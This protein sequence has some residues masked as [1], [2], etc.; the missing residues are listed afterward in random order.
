[1]RY[2]LDMPI[3]LAV[4]EAEIQGDA[5]TAVNLMAA[6]LHTR[7]PD[8]VFWRP[9]RMHRLVQLS[10]LAS[11]LPRWATS[12][13]ILAQAH[14][15]V[16]PGDRDRA[17]QAMEIAIE[18]RGPDTLWGVDEIDAR[19]KVMDHDW[20]YRQVLLY[21]LG[22]LQHFIGGVASRKLLGGADRIHD[23]ARAPMGAF[24]LQSAH[25]STLVWE[26]LGSGDRVESLN[27]GSAAM[28]E[29]GECAIGRLVPVREGALFEGTPLYVPDDTARRVAADPT[30]WVTVLT[31]AFRQ[32]DTDPR[33]TAVNPLGDGGLL[34]DVPL[35]VAY[36][37][38]HLWS[39]ATTVPPEL[40]TEW[41]VCLRHELV[42]AAVQGRIDDSSTAMRSW[43]SVTASLLDPGVLEEL[44]SSVRAEDAP[45]LLELA[46]LLPEPAGRLCRQLAD[47]AHRSTASLFRSATR[48]ERSRST[49][50]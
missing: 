29:L 7:G 9:E 30:G 38:A 3:V 50:H 47:E 45:G 37:Q 4:D 20:V 10:L 36:G 6:D 23:W 17:M 19:A 1:M 34:S 28:L 26:D 35:A 25:P 33:F 18:T 44:S 49:R 21:E 32:K 24:R 27:I 46:E 8:E 39:G 16:H 43:P 2:E 42:R 48:V 11:L 15:S 5:E 40:T 12:R 14:Q 13:W 31:E 22:G 41:A